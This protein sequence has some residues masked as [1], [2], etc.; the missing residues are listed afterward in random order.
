MPTHRAIAPG[1][2]IKG[3]WVEPA[4]SDLIVDN[5]KLWAEQS[6]VAP[7]RIP[8]Y[9]NRDPSSTWG[10][11]IVIPHALPGE[12]VIYALHGGA[13]VFFSAHSSSPTYNI[14]SALLSSLRTS[15][16]KRAFSLEYRLSTTE[17]YEKSG[18]FP[19]ALLDALSGYVH[20]LDLGFKPEDV[21]VV[22]DSAGGNIALAL[23]RYLV[24][25]RQHASNSADKISVPAPPGNLLLLSPW[26]DPSNS[27]DSPTSSSYTCLH[28][29]YIGALTSNTNAYSRVAFLGP[30]VALLNNPYISPASLHL[31]PEEI[32]FEGFPKTFISAGGAEVLRDQIRTLKERMER[33]M[34]VRVKY[35]ETEDAVHDFLIFPWLQPQREE[36]LG[37][38]R[39]WFVSG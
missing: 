25:H 20:L 3:V 7:V 31:L 19:A 16:V 33:D 28:S 5:L 37:R 15:G 13:F 6:R 4:P 10:D 8:G 35:E 23:T 14:V 38:I 11:P 29:D 21:L 17:P 36:L 32:S 9:W 30:H 24:E 26:A 2:W 12:K 34:G 27:H 1:K 39:E 18:A 22:G